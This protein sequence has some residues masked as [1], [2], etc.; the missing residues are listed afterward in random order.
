MRFVPRHAAA[1]AVTLLL[2]VSAAPARATNGMYLAGYGSQSAGRGGA[3]LGVADNALGLQSNPAGIMHIRG[4]ELDVDLQ[5]LAPSLQYGGDPLGNKIDGE[6]K[7]FAMPGISYVKGYAD[8]P[9]T[10]GVALISQGGMGATFK[11]YTTPFGTID[12]TSSEVRF[13]TL[14][15]TVAYK[16]NEKFALGTSVNVG[17]SDVTFGFW[18]GTSYYNDGGTPSDPTDD[19]GFFGAELTD[20]PTAWTTSVRLGGLWHATPKFTLGAVYQTETT[21]DYENG[22]LTLDETSLGQ[23][24][25]NYD[26]TVTGFRWPAQYGAGV[27]LRP[28]KRWMLAADVRCYLWKHA[29]EKITVKGTNPN[30]LMVTGAEMVF[31][32]RWKDQWVVNGGAEF[33]AGEEFTVRAGYNYG[34]SPV[35]DETLNP[36]FPAI[37]EQHATAGLSWKRADHAINAAIERAFEASQTNMNTNMSENPFGPG[38]YVD[39]SQWTFSLGYSRAF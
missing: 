33:V 6:S 7:V 13:A 20:R 35:P 32:F 25:V 8:Q 11:G 38:M 26:A 3:N 4:R 34:A 2:V 12:E 22:T 28:A 16:F 9:W 1:L 18:P 29:M 10:W 5:L 14:T 17:Y 39:H 27:E 15:P 24:K 19:M 37:T 31:P 30:A 23:G 36:L 21:G